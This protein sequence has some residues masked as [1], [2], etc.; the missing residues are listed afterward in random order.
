MDEKDYRSIT[1]MEAADLLSVLNP[2]VI[3]GTRRGFVPG[4]FLDL[5]PHAI[6]RDGLD[7]A[8]V[9]PYLVAGWQ[10]Q[11]L[12]LRILEGEINALKEDNEILRRRLRER[13]VIQ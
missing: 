2:V 3:R 8:Q 12:R 5:I 13:D 1:L 11:N 10:Q 9:I 4:E 7:T 6:G